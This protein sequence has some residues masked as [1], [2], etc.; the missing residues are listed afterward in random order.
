MA[1]L[2]SI[3]AASFLGSVIGFLQI[4]AVALLYIKYLEPFLKENGNAPVPSCSGAPKCETGCGKDA[5]SGYK[6]CSECMSSGAWKAHE[7]VVAKGTGT[8]FSPAVVDEDEII[9]PEDDDAIRC[10]CGSIMVRD[11]AQFKCVNCGKTKSAEVSHDSMINLVGE[12]VLGEEAT[13]ADKD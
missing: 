12:V 4:T 2:F 1:L 8:G 7:D 10:E 6:Y 9:S 11:G 3:S 5:A 13:H